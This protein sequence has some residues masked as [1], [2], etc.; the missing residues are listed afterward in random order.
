MLF[1]FLG[2]KSYEGIVNRKR[3][4]LEEAS[5]AKEICPIYFDESIIVAEQLEASKSENALLMKGM[6]QLQE[7]IME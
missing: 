7:T 6:L 1:V 5:R 3:R 4:S 2:D